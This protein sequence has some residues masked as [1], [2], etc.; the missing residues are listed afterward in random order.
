MT[1]IEKVVTYSFQE[2]RATCATLG[3]HRKAPGSAGGT[4]NR[5]NVGKSLYC[6]FWGKEQVRQGQQVRIGWFESFHGS[7]A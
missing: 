6:D 1:A 4:G 3:P 5:R 7:G 2:E